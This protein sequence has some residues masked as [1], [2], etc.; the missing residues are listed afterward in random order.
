MV[1]MSIF[2]MIG[3][4]L[5]LSLRS[6]VD[7]WARTEERRQIY[8]DA[9]ALL[10]QVREDLGAVA[11]TGGSGGD[12]R[13]LFLCDYDRHNRQRLRFVR[14]LKAEGARTLLRMAGTGTEEEGYTDFY[15]EKGGSEKKLR[16][17]GGLMEVVY[18]YDPDDSESETLYRGVRAPIGGKG[19]LFRNENIDSG[20]KV[21]EIATPISSKALY[22]GFMFWSQ[23]TSTWDTSV[24]VS[25]TLGSPSGPEFA[26]DSSRGILPAKPSKKKDP[27]FFTLAANDASRYVGADDIFPRQVQVVLSIRPG[28]SYGMVTELADSLSRSERTVRVVSAR[29]FPDETDPGVYRYIRIGTE[30]FHFKTREGNA[31]LVD[32]RGARNSVAS[33]HKQGMAVRAGRTFVITASI[34]SYREYWFGANPATGLGRVKK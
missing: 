28:T 4:M 9:Q 30:W 3:G 26:W 23:Y 22:L 5:L 18:L 32:R 14:T 6:G 10:R 12:S 1:A 21:M 7:T 17:L 20:K 19:S 25:N 34:P 15:T 33:G 24:G 2:L 27:N 29:G 11:S 31:F 16:P 8:E 13:I